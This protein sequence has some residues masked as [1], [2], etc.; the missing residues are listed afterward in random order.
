MTVPNIDSPLVWTERL[1]VSVFPPEH[2][3]SRH[4]KVYVL[5]DTQW[6]WSVQ[7]GPGSTILSRD[8]HWGPF[9]GAAHA[10]ETWVR[11]HYYATQEEAVAAAAEAAKRLTCN[12]MTVS[13][14]IAAGE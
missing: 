12:G 2:R 8:G 14:A 11:L 1:A 10:D 4:F 7:N 6:G 3:A 9:S 5:W 13:E